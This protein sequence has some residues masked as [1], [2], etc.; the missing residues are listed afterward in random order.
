MTLSSLYLKRVS[1]TFD[2]IDHYVILQTLSSLGFHKIRFFFV[3]LLPYCTSLFNYLCLLFL[4]FF[5]DQS[6]VLLSPLSALWLY[7]ILSSPLALNTIYVLLTHKSVL[8]TWHFTWVRPHKTFAISKSFI[9]QVNLFFIQQI[10]S[11]YN[12]PYTV[13]AQRIQQWK[14]NKI[15]PLQCLIG[16]SNVI[17]NKSTLISFTPKSAS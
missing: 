9:S 2:T 11:A 16:I 15:S 12:V 13:K 4:L 14:H 10:L 8:Y 5:S 7:M 3:F 17:H 1:G 6:L